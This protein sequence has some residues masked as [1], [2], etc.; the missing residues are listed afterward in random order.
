MTSSVIKMVQMHKTII[1]CAVT[2]SAPSPERNPAV[3]VSPSEIATS[4]IEAAK[5]GAAIV[6]CHVRNPKTSLPSMD[7]TLYQEVA[8]RIRSADTDV[9]L[10]L[11]TGP[12]ARYSPSPNDAGI[13]SSN[14]NMRSPTERIK[15]IR[16]I[17]PEICS[18]DVA[19][20]NRKSYVFLNHPEHLIEMSL[21]IKAAGVKPELEVFDTG[22][23]LNAISL[24]ES[25][26]INSPPFFQFC[27]GVDY[28][29]PATV[30]A[31]IMMK[32]MLPPGAI[33]SAFG[34][35]RF[36]FPMVA[37]SVLS[38]GHVRVGLED[39]LYLEKGVLASSNA[40]LVQKAVRIINDLGGSV[41]SVDEA[42]E[43]LSL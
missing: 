36:Q 19:T 7:L 33:W 8:E 4:A 18:L 2:G 6:H 32:N 14:S 27:L 16:D 23:I 17:Q 31:I 26:F 29:A 1:S 40:A 42:R 34:I 9:I 41:A 39:N 22:H 20:M 21:A 37:A 25:G 24:I 38:G 30:E 12:G 10:N 3:P 11:T 28:G 35:S 13:A 15:H 43:L 5:A